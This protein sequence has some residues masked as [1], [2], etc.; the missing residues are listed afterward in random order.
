MEH[1][2]L[3]KL[4]YSK[5]WWIQ[6]IGQKSD[7]I[8]GLKL[9][10]WIMHST[11]TFV[12]W[13][14]ISLPMI[15]ITRWSSLLKTWSKTVDGSGTEMTQVGTEIENETRWNQ[16]ETIDR[17]LLVVGGNSVRVQPW[18]RCWSFRRWPTMYASAGESMMSNSKEYHQTMWLHEDVVQLHRN[19]YLL[20]MRRN[21]CHHQI[22]QGAFLWRFTQQHIFC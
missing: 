22:R 18:S 1:K 17:R 12:S 4:F 16:K 10:W 6:W 8:R 7:Y 11:G 14:L 15:A 19:F 9:A 5:D 21:I 20:L 2:W 13:Q 3:H